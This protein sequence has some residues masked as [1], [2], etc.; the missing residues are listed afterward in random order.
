VATEHTAE[1]IECTQ[2]GKPQTYDGS[3]LCSW[4]ACAETG[5]CDGVQ[6]IR[7]TA[8][9]DA[10]EPMKEQFAQQLREKDALIA[11]LESRLANAVK[12]INDIERGRNT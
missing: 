11:E 3:G 7:V 12:V 2:C 10:I 8:F 4:R 5:S 6:M 1:K 9:Y